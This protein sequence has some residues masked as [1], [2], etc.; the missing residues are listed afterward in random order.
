MMDNRFNHRRWCASAR[1]V[2]GLIVT[3]AALTGACQTPPATVPNAGADSNQNELPRE[4]VT[5]V[6]GG[7]LVYNVTAP[8]KTFNYMLAG[9]EPSTTT[10]FYLLGGRL[11]EYDDERQAYV[12]ALAESWKLDADGR[13]G[14]L[15]LRDGLKFSDGAPLTA[16]DVAFTLRTLY[17]ERTGSPIYRDA[18]LVGGKPIEATVLDARR[19]RLVFP[20]TVAVPENYLSNI[21]VLPRHILADA[22][23]RGE[24]GKAYA[25][26][27]APAR[28][29]TAG[30]FVVESIVPGERVTLKR[31]PFYWKRDAAGTPLP[32][33]DQLVIEVVPD[34]NNAVTRLGQG[35]LDIVDRVRPSDF[36]NLRHGGTGGGGGNNVRAYD[37]G[38]GLYTDDLWFNLNGGARPDGQPLVEANKRAWFNDVRFRRAISHALDRDNIAANTWQGLATPLYG[39]V[40]GGNR[41]WVAADLPRTE[42]DLDKARALFKEAGFVSRGSADAPELYDARG[43]RVTFTVLVQATNEQRVKTA[44]VIQE[45]LKRLGIEMQVATTDTG[46][47]QSRLFQSFDYDAVLFGASVSEPDPSSYNDTIRSDSAQ[48]F[49]W[50]NEPK[51]ATEWEA[52]LD[53]LSTRQ[54]HEIDPDKRRAIFRDIQIILAEQLPLIPVVTRHIAVAVN[55]RVGNYRP[56]TLPPFSLWNA[57]ELFIKK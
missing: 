17:D 40:A 46:Q 13:A 57:E 30:R 49:W 26:T 53:E 11:F 7:T 32:Y 54:A 4:R 22:A 24:V 38:P 1:A 27:E 51:P 37:L 47:M 6:R 43:N 33:L 45:D 16:D 5:G 41:Q 3:L 21:A 25:L 15:T 28:I 44:A 48:H 39:F 2:F 10:S 12:P 34:Q 55:Q 31:N 50:P 9:D 18:T 56:S 35:T 20:E 29:V 14:E 42:Y 52:R 8:P 36:A 23:A 19:L